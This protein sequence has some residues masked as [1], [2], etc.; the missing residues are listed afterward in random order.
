M[1]SKL[2]LLPRLI[3]S[4]CQ[5]GFWYCST[6]C[7]VIRHHRKAPICMCV[8]WLQQEIL[9]AVPS[10]DAWPETYRSFKVLFF[11]LLTSFSSFRLIKGSE[12]HG[13]TGGSTTFH[14]DEDDDVS[15][16]FA[17]EKPYLCDFT[18]CGRGFSRSDQLK[19]HQR[20]HTGTKVSV[21][22]L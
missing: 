6:S 21:R 18:D 13:V 16:L 11:C 8:S 19:R 20:R 22:F 4:G 3:L 2:C 1:L 12:T 10:A 15:V 7:E 9:Q 5:T 17:G 14:L